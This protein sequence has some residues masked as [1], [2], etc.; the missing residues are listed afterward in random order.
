MAANF[1]RIKTSDIS[2]AG[3]LL[4]TAPANT[5]VIIIGFVISNKSANQIKI[6][7]SASDIQITGTDTPIP[8]GSALSI[9]D[10]KI[11]LEP[12]DQVL[13]YCDQAASADSFISLLEMT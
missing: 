6:K 12:G 9:L 13:A 7:V 5:K 10:G 11:V 8:S 3:T 1:K 2:L 4:Y